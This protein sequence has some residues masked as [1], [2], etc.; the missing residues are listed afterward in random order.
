MWKIKSG[1]M[2]AENESTGKIARVDYGADGLY[3]V[4]KNYRTLAVFENGEDAKKCLAELVKKLNGEIEN[5]G[6]H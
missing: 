4:K 2:F 1:G 5:V 6:T 3:R